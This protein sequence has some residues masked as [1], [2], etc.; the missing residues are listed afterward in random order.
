MIHIGYSKIV[1][2]RGKYNRIAVGNLYSTFSDHSAI[3]FSGLYPMLRNK[4]FS[5]IRVAC[6]SFCTYFLYLP[7]WYRNRKLINNFSYYILFFKFN[8]K[9]E[10]N[11][12]LFR[13]PLEL[14]LQ[15]LFRL[16]SEIK[17]KYYRLNRDS[18]NDLVCLIV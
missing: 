4:D 6:S 8:L 18:Y 2:N 7:F 17:F 1:A 14:I 13:R 12:G 3:Y 5:D 15:C 9:I 11:F 16:D 10:E